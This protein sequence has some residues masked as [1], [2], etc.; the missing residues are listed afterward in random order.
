MMVPGEGLDPPSP[1][2]SW[3]TE[4]KTLTALADQGFLEPSIIEEYIAWN[5]FAVLRRTRR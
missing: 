5:Q 2:R 4:D 3:A 1:L